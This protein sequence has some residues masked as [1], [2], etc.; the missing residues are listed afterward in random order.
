MNWSVLTWSA[1][2]LWLAGSL[3]LAIAELLA[4]GFFL[5]FVAAAAAVTGFVVLAAPG[6]HAITQVVLFALFGAIAIILGRGWYRRLREVTVDTGLNDR[7]GKLIGKTVE[8]CDAIVAGE[9]RV[10]VGDGAW[11]AR[12]PDT[13]VGALVRI[14]GATGSVL[15]VEPA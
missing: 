11:N 4:P 10:R 3:L 14:V 15:L 8:V 6:L 2:A 9:G 5:I 13:P 1:G 7:T 12:G